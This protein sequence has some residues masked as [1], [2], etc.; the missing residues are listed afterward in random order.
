MVGIFQYQKNCD[1]N[2]CKLEVLLYILTLWA[3]YEVPDVR[4]PTRDMLQ[5]K[6]ITT[7]FKKWQQ[8]KKEMQYKLK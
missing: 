2:V 6:G 7:N 4:W 1:F 8:M 3:Q 5:T